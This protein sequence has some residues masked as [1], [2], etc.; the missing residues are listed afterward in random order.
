[1]LHAGL[2]ER[3]VNNFLSVLNLNTL[4]KPTLKARENEIGTVFEKAAEESQQK[5]AIEELKKTILETPVCRKPR[6]RETTKRSSSLQPK[7]GSSHRNARARSTSPG[8]CTVGMHGS[9]DACY[10]KRGSQKS[11]N[12]LSGASTII[13]VRTKKVINSALRCKQ[14]KLCATAQKDGRKP[15]AHK[16]QK[17]WDGS[18]K[19]ME[20]D[21]F[22]DMIS[23]MK[24]KGLGLQAVSGDDDNTGF[25]RAKLTIDPDL[26]KKK[27]KN[28][29]RK[30]VTTKLF[31][32]RNTKKYKELSVT[33]IMGLTKYFNY[34]LTQNQGNPAGIRRGLR[35][36]VAHSFGSHTFCSPKWCKLLKNKNG[37]HANLPRGKSLTSPLLRKALTKIFIKD[38]IP[39]AEQLAQ[40][41]SSQGNESFNMLL[42]RKAPKANHYSSS[43]SL[44]FR[45][46]AAV[47]QKNE[48]YSYVPDA[49]EKLGLSPGYSTR[50]RAHSLD[51]DRERQSA[52]RQTKEYKK[53][54]I[55]LKSSRAGIEKSNEILEGETY[56]SEIALSKTPDLEKIPDIYDD[57]KP[58]P[59]NACEI[60]FDLET[61]DLKRDCDITQIVA[62]T[63]S[64]ETFSTYVLPIKPISSGAT[65]QHK[66]K[67]F[68]N[69]LYV[70][71][72]E[73]QTV[74][75]KEGIVSFIEFLQKHK[76]VVLIGHNIKTYDMQVLLN[77]LRIYGL[78]ETL[79]EISVGIVDTK[80]LAKTIVPKDACCNQ[81]ALVLKFLEKTYNA[82]NAFD[83]VMVLHEL[84]DKIKPE[85]LK[86][87]HSNVMSHIRSCED[88]KVLETSYSELIEGKAMSMSMASKAAKSGLCLGHLKKAVERDSI[89]G[90][91]SLLGHK[92]ASGKPRVTKAKYI[93][94]R[95]FDAIGKA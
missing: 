1:M 31:Q 11:Y 67:T 43:R 33:A 88:S 42:V 41:G 48:G 79:C 85:I 64:G 59:E 77:K 24:K 45:L 62:K 4:S 83:D 10:Q 37:K 82:H 84:W 8:Y 73:V 25:A 3:T 21:M 17:N 65:K 89:D 56:G 12:S 15:K 80:V 74:S 16:C 22:C 91:T 6:I 70:G 26:Q 7:Q 19:A 27:D 20:P 81:Q 47:S 86:K 61:T 90:L 66:M 52:I 13:G 35:A 36:I 54:R 46:A 55:E 49:H 76:P 30:G 57:D 72:Q 78:W 32:L 23:S 58:I 68:G 2:G 44:S 40:L 18:A 53:R 95:I 69:K 92:R 63:M 60:I 34:M 94:Q 71:D 87:N 14:C 39:H 50:K 9:S 38:L 28:H 29:V 93:I 75:Q 5:W 51:H